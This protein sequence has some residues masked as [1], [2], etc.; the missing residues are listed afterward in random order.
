MKQER[1]G[2]SRSLQKR[3]LAALLVTTLS[4]A[5]IPPVTAEPAY[6]AESVCMTEP[7]YAAA[8][9]E[10]WTTIT[11]PVKNGTTISVRDGAIYIDSFP[12]VGNYQYAF[13]TYSGPA[14][15]YKIF[16]ISEPQPLPLPEKDGRYNI[17]IELS[18]EHKGPS[19]VLVHKLRMT[20]K[21]GRA[22]FPKSPVYDHNLKLQQKAAK[23]NAPDWYYTMQT[24]STY[25]QTQTEK[26][27][28][29]KKVKK[30]AEEIVDAG[31]SDYV[32]IQKVHDWVA[33]NIWYDYDD[34]HG[35]AAGYHGE[36]AVLEHKRGVCEDYAKLTAA[37]LRSLGI[38]AK[39]ISGEVT[40][41]TYNDDGWNADG[42]PKYNLEG[43]AWNEAYADGRWIILD[44]T[45]D[46]NNSYKNGKF[47]EKADPDRNY[48]DPPLEIFSLNHKAEEDW[49]KKL[50]ES[51]IYY[52]GLR[53][54]TYSMTLKKGK[55]KKLTVKTDPNMKFINLKKDAKITFSSN[56]KKVAT[57]SKKGVVKAKKSGQAV[58]TTTVKIADA[59]IEI[60]TDVWVP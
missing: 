40:Y 17:R 33:A 44:T 22:F 12:S 57:V 1:N 13:F 14:T 16:P 52:Y 47:S 43:H 29:E 48:F 49:Q 32:K 4:V 36:K 31:D 20:V 42:T 56:N 24:F 34:Y 39:V 10:G 9:D 23:L 37:L 38:P 25:F 7:V 35:I 3:L 5:C 46:S 59:V 21:D 11:T 45:W 27:A 26:K 51:E 18:K 30:Q 6:A 8:Q 60:E 50:R 15:D 55:T 54:S 58:I 28:F 19:T 2:N 53:I 41:D